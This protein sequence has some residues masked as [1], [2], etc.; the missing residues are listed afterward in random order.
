MYP[1]LVRVCVR[2]FLQAELAKSGAE[3]VPLKGV[4][5]KLY[6][7]KSYV[8]PELVAARCR[9]QLQQPG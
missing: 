9:R 2:A 7:P 4:F 1:V 8:P 5:A 6:D 3:V